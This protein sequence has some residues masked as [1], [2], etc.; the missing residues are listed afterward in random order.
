MVRK[1][2]VGSANTL[3]GQ[4]EADE[5]GA[6]ECD[7]KGFYP[8]GTVADS[9]SASGMSLWASAG[10]PCGSNF[11][12]EAFLKSHPEYVWQRE[13][14][15]DMPSGSWT[16]FSITGFQPNGQNARTGAMR[17]GADKNPLDPSQKRR[18]PGD[19]APPLPG[20]PPPRLP[21]DPRPPIP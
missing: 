20:D 3:C 19:P 6:P 12:L 14:A 2:E 10:H 8:G 4:V 7:W 16:M 5:R 11:K 15:G 17:K 1:R 13:I 18:V 9:E 21:G